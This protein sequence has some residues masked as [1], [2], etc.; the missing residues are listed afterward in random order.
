VSDGARERLLLAED[1]AGHARDYYFALPRAWRNTP[2]RLV[3]T[4]EES[5]P[6]GWVA[7]SVPPATHVSEAAVS[8]LVPALLAVFYLLIVLVPGLAVALALRA[9]PWP[10][11]GSI[12]TG[13]GA[14]AMGAF[15][16]AWLY[17]QGGL[18]IVAVLWF[19]ALAWVVARRAPLAAVSREH[20]LLS[21]LALTCAALAFN[22][23]AGFLYGGF[24]VPLGVA[25][26]R[27][28]HPLPVDN[29]IPLFFYK[30]LL[31]GHIPSPLVAD[32]QS[33]DRPPLQTAFLLAT[34][35]APRLPFA[36]L[37]QH[38]QALGMALQAFWLPALWMTLRRFGLGA[39]ATLVATAA[40]LVGPVP[41][42]HGLFIWPKLLSGAYVLCAAG[43]ILP[44]IA[45]GERPGI[46]DAAGAS[47]AGALSMLAHGGG[48]FGVIAIGLLAI[49][50]RWRPGLR[51]IAAA[52]LVFAVLYGPWM[53]YQKLADPPGDRLARQFLAGQRY[54]PNETLGD[55]LA[56]AYSVPAATLLANRVENVVQAAG[57]PW[58]QPG[59]LVRLA[60]AGSFAES[61]DT[62]VQ[63]RGALF[64][65]VL[66]S[67]WLPLL[68]ALLAFLA[69]RRA[70][71]AAA[72]A[73]RLL[74]ACT[75]VGLTAW[76]LVVYGPGATQVHTGSLLFPLLIACASVL[77][78]WARF[79]R[80]TVAWVAVYCAIQAWVYWF[81]PPVALYV[82]D[83][84]GAVVGTLLENGRSA[85]NTTLT[86]LLGVLLLGV[87][88][89]CAWRR[90][91]ETART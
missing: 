69:R 64:F 79:P 65:R 54:D 21:V 44:P 1:P 43:F 13:A 42:V 53:A 19:A 14:F 27:Y 7:F 48:F 34:H 45:R 60:S 78:S 58:Q 81:Y 56:R 46:A 72:S 74:Y 3:G 38:Y 9:T 16:I 47:A 5:A 76:I 40:L 55:A 71:G 35:F 90:F 75:A 22:A 2:L 49:A 57:K 73:A 23:A 10:P 28:S 25:Q 39:R 62:L 59:L 85:A 31:S 86:A 91:G 82:P 87:L 33:S 51:A 4:D 11:L 41:I 37:D 32:A 20:G 68:A 67:M 17:P 63:I 15:W 8:V 30:A 70:T 12:L 36:T 6:D 61:Y 52:C 80:L 83:L 66:E 29:A 50:V 18:L 24:D 89:W 77:A 88:L 26:V 84:D